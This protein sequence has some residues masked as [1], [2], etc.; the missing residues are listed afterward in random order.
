M[1]FWDILKSQP[2][3]KDFL[4]R[5]HEKISSQLQTGE[6]E[7]ITKIACIAG[8]FAR[9]AYAD[10]KIQTAEIEAMQQAL[11]K[12]SHLSEEEVQIISHLA[13]EEMIELSGLENHKYTAPLNDLMDENERYEIL[14]SLFSIAA[15]DGN[16]EHIEAEEIRLITQGLKLT[17]RHF[18][19]ARATVMEYLGALKK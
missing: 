10:M 17:P 5:L 15:S 12:W 3:K 8:L 18:T 1:G 14:E 6:E 9:V 2:F 4:S 11:S 7:E 13:I 19:S 16:A